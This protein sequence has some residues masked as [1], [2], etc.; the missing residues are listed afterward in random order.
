MTQVIV[1]VFD[2]SDLLEIAHH[3]NGTLTVVT[4]ALGESSMAYGFLAPVYGAA[5]LRRR[6]VRYLA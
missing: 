3:A 5:R 4:L 1:A 6:V 2:S